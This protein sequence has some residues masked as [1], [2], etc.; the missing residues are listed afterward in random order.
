MFN[1]KLLILTLVLLK[2]HNFSGCGPEKKVSE[3]PPLYDLN[4]P[5]KITLP[6]AL[7]EISGISFYPKDS[8]VFAEIDED[9]LL[10]KVSLNGNNAIKQ[11][12]YDKKHDFEDIVMHDSTFYILESNGDI[13]TLKFVGDSIIKTKSKYP[14]ADKK[15]NEFETLY[16][17]NS[18]GLVMLCKNCEDDKKKVVTAFKC[19]P[20][21]SVYDVAFQIDVKPIEEKAKEE[22]FH[23]KPS[24]AAINPI[25]NELYILASVNK[26]LVVA[27]RNGKVKDVYELDPVTFNQP[28]GINFTPWGDLLISNEKGEKDAATILIFKPKKKG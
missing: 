27:D 8:S 19:N 15:T 20:D 13:E 7:D 17:D 28:E 24:A 16:Y 9:G 25:T 5:V 22:N 18:L 23:F 4:N 12:R 14:D 21:S 6:S 26:L 3:S 2:F 10:F 11:W 1:G